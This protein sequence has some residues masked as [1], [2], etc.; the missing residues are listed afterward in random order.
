MVPCWCYPSVPPRFLI[1]SCIDVDSNTMHLDPDPQMC[2]NLDPDPSLFTQLRYKFWGKFYILFW[3]IIIYFLKNI[4]IKNYPKIMAL[5]ESSKLRWWIF[6]HQS[7]LFPLFLIAWIRCLMVAFW[8]KF[9]TMV[10]WLVIGCVLVGW[11]FDGRDYILCSRS[12]AHSILYM[13]HLT[14]SLEFIFITCLSIE[15]I[16]FRV[17]IYFICSFLYIGYFKPF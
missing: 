17:F 6:I 7:S 13:D 5:E 8:F 4:F 11:W 14:E 2:P 12:D 9:L 3:L 15:K 1:V 10:S 16:Q